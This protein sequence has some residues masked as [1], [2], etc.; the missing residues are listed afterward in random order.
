MD[1]G[2]WVDLSN[3]THDHGPSKESL[4]CAVSVSGGEGE[5]LTG[6]RGA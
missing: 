1:L 6:L 2:L 3:G 5:V 4:G